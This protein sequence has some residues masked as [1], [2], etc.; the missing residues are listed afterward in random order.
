MKITRSIFLFIGSLTAATLGTLSA[1]PSWADQLVTHGDEFVVNTYT[2]ANQGLPEVAVDASGRFVVVWESSENTGDA[3]WG[4][5][6]QRYAADGTPLGDEVQV[7]SHTT[8]LQVLPFVATGAGGDFVVVWQSF[9]QVD[10]SSDFDIFGQRFDSDG[11]TIGDEFQ[12]NSYTTG[13]QGHPAV[14]VSDDGGFLILWESEAQDL[15]DDGIYG[16]LFDSTGA[17]LSGEFPVNS[18]TFSDQNDPRVVAIDG[19]F[20]AVWEDLGFDGS[21]ETVV[22]Q[23]LDASAGFVGGEIQVNT[24]TGDDQEDPAIAV[25]PDGSFA[26]TWESDGQD[27]NVEG[28]FAQVFDSNG[29]PSGDELQVNTETLD[30]QANP[31]IAAD[32]QGGYLVVWESFNQVAQN[33]DYDIFGQR[34]DG[35]GQLLGGEFKVNSQATD[36][37]D[38]VSIAGSID[39]RFLVAWRSFGGHDGSEA[40]VYAQRYELALF[41][42]GFETGTTDAWTAVVPE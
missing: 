42:D 30:D 32:G 36:G 18:T 15:S 31:S 11:E 34:I 38:E 20:L 27:G 28:V 25:S 29:S 8:D 21:N 33:S 24:W 41:V 12:V 13:Y 40:G 7:N 26:V 17:S 23:E 10:A 4:V 19:G 2:T 14:T 9:A 16:H 1:S 5:F 39:G 6:C 3:D 35:Q 22:L 37:Q